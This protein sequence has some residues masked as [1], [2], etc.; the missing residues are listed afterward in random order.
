MKIKYTKK[1]PKVKK[2]TNKLTE[3]CKIANKYKTDKVETY[4]H[5]YTKIYY[6]LLNK[7]RNSIK[8][9]LEIGIGT[10]EIMSG[11]PNY[12]TGASLFMWRDFFKNAQII[13][14]DILEQ[15]KMENQERITTYICNSQDKEQSDKILRKI[16]KE[17][18]IIIDDGDH[19]PDGQLRTFNIFF[20][21]LKRSGTYIIEDV[22]YKYS[23][24]IKDRLKNKFEE[25]EISSYRDSNPICTLFIIKRIL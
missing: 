1:E 21:Y 7:S 25:I 19:S 5:A 4:G 23:Q 22:E 18:D 16:D 15:C 11:S 14:I 9:I 10:P 3:L 8:N 17:F 20:P 2:N 6:S 13:G 24:Y 12:C